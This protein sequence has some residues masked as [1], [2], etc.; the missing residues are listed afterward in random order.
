LPAVLAGIGVGVGATLARLGLNELIGID[1]GYFVLLAASVVAAWYTGMVGGVVAAVTTVLL[2]LPP[3]VGGETPGEV[4]RAEL[5]RLALYLAVAT[6]TAVLVAG[7]RAA[8]MRLEAVTIEVADLAEKI[9]DR[10]R[11]LELM[12]AASGTGFWEW[13][14]AS[15]ALDWS[16]AIF[17]Q[18]GLDPAADPPSFEAYLDTIHP[19]DRA[20]FQDA[21]RASLEDDVPLSM[22][23]RVVWTDGTVHWT[24]G[25]GRVMRDET[26]RPLRMLGTG[27]DVTERHRLQD[28]RDRLVGEERRAAVYR[29][30]F[31][32]VISHELR[33]PI[34]SILGLTQILSRPGR[35]DD[36]AA[37]LALLDD[38]R[39]E[40]ERLH[41]L[42]E[43]LLVLSRAERG[44]LTAE[45]EPIQLARLLERIVQREATVLP[46]IDITLAQEPRLPIVAGEETYVE[47]VVRN[48]L[49]NAAK[50]CPPGT[51]VIVEVARAG[52][53]FVGVT[54]RDEGPGISE[55]AASRVFELFY[56]DP[57]RAKTVSGSGIG[58][59]VCAALV[60]SMGG[61]IWATR[62]TERGSAF[63]FTLPIHESDEVVA[64]PATGMPRLTGV[65]GAPGPLSESEV[66]E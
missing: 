16:D 1:P 61:R 54:V 35:T 47:Q 59:F 26:G 43:D 13:D 33:T 21:L 49:G 46:T 10:D 38:I 37:R 45:A 31:V 2:G 51:R 66:A 52:E 17:E 25:A 58:L 9:E 64:E 53:A 63:S 18:H 57:E 36:P 50:Y 22:D 60:E 41:R 29:E 3:V 62:G 56:R 6:A 14:V 34:T 15:G 28:E 19:D 39:A 8:A 20:A 30:A 4:D 65:T 40:S 11:R 7:R 55:E 32:D 5:V 12:L 44:R 27:Q 48:L 23:F 42:I 24:H